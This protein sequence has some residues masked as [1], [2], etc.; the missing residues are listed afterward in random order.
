MLAQPEA[1]D[2]NTHIRLVPTGLFIGDEFIE[3]T[4]KET[5]DVLNP[6]SGELLGA[7]S[8]ACDKD[9][10]AAV[11]AASSAF[12]KHWRS[13]SGAVRGLLLLKLAALIERDADLFATIHAVDGGF[14]SEDVKALDIKMA[15]STL[16][17]FSGW[18][19]KISGRVTDIE[20]GTGIVRKEPLGVCGLVVPWNAPL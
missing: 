14:V 17:H 4:S 20:N 1:N 8:L 6:Y 16:R 9:V 15:V 13:T 11:D 3:S 7:I 18:A 2:G 10:D 5:L 12:R 19:D